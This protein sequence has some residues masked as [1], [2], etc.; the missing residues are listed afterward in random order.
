MDQLANPARGSSAVSGDPCIGKTSLL[1]YLCEPQVSERWG[2]SPSWCHFLYLDCH[3]IVPFSETAFWRHTLRELKQ[4]LSDDEDLSGQVQE[5]LAQTS[6][7]IFDLNSLFDQIARA[8]R[9]A[10]LMLDE[11]EGVVENLDQH[12]PRLLYHLRSLLNRRERGLAL[13]V[14]TRA[15]LK[16]LCAD[17]RFAGSPFDNAFSAIVLPPFSEAEVDELLNQYQADF[18]A[19]ESS[20]LHQMAGTHPYL[21]QLTA[22]LIIRARRDH[23]TAETSLGQ[24]EADLEREAERYFSDMF[25]YS[26]E[27]EKMLM[28]WLALYPL[29]QHLPTDTTSLGELSKIFARYDQETAYLVKRGLVRLQPD[30]PVLFSPIFGRWILRQVIIAGGPELLSGWESHYATLLSPVERETL[31]NLV[32]KLVRWP[33]IVR[34]PELLAKVFVQDE[35]DLSTTLAGRQVLGRYVIEALIGGGGMADV[36]KARDIR[37]DRLVAVKKLRPTLSEAGEVQTRFRREAQAVAG[38]RHPHIVRVH[39]FDIQ[40]GH[41]YMVMEFIE[42]H[43]LKEHLHNLEAVG[44]TLSWEEVLRIAVPVADA[45][46]YAHQQ[47]MIHRDVKPANILL[48]NDGGVF[49]ADF[50]LVRLLGQSDLTET[51]GLLGTLA[52]MAPEQLMGQSQDIDYRAD[53]YALGC[54]VYKMLTGRTPFESGELPLAH[55]NTDPLAPECLVP[56]LPKRAS[57]VIL[58]ALAKDPAERPASASQF[59]EDLRQALIPAGN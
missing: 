56:E 42:G 30:R 57:Q 7:D 36:F 16:Q 5:L 25:G 20:F 51:G 35:V 47:D 49:L 38:L 23:T 1:H 53:I 45:L 59:I 14:A 2:L 17:F 4:Y 32:D 10:V 39:D 34:T 6:P 11:F 13:L 37:L 46:D 33:A 15:P 40:S 22:S 24:V 26:S 43:N 3:S 31:V 44:Q 18:S 8:D 21:V 55:L 52:Y 28:T 12:E 58:K 9:L 48:A 29:S 54:V 50:G 19:T 27:P 41:Y